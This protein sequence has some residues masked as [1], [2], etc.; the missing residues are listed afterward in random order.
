MPLNHFKAKPVQL[1]S[2]ATVPADAIIL[3]VSRIISE[4][5]RAVRDAFAWGE[6]RGRYFPI[7]D[8]QG[9]NC[10]WLAP[11]ARSRSLAMPFLAL[12]FQIEDLAGVSRVDVTRYHEPL[13]AGFVGHDGYITELLG[14]K[15][16]ILLNV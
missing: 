13:T 9:I 14:E 8:S 6:E 3:V 1:S 5:P 2:T 15:W 10:F 4:K 11:P 16:T 7:I 12:R